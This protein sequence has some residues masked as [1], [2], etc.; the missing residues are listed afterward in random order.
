MKALIIGAAGFVGNYLIR[1]L[2]DKGWDVGATK[3]PEEAI[4]APKAVQVFDLDILSPENTE[5]VVA[6]YQPD[7]IFHLA[8]VSSVALSWKKPELTLKVNILG[9]LHVLEAVRKVKKDTRILLIGSSD[10]YGKISPEELPVSEGKAARPENIYA[11]SKATQNMLGDTYGKA[12]DMD[13]IRIRAFNHIGPG[14]LPDFAASSFAQQIACIEAGLQQP[15]ISVGNLEAERDFSDVRDI[16]AAYE[17]LARK[18]RKGETYNVGSG[19]SVKLQTILDKLLALSTA[20]IT[21]QRDASRF[22]PTDMPCVRADIRKLQ[23]DTGWATAIPLEQT[24][25]AM[26]DHWR[27]KIAE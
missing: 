10:E 20:E 27:E 8:A 17:A 9:A 6:Q 22:R 5:E 2:L 7:V 24:L 13:V 21:V 1:E 12:Y 19:R 26:L 18:G 16:V 11:I 15:V 25:Q 3:L 14:Q 4:S 23:Q